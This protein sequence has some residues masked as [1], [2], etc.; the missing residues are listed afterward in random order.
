[1]GG[2]AGGNTAG[3]AGGNASAPNSDRDAGVQGGLD[4]AAAPADGDA[5]DASMSDG[6][7]A[8]AVL[9]PDASVSSC[10]GFGCGTTLS[11]LTAA[12][13]DG[14]VCVTAEALPLACDGELSRAAEQCT[15][16][17]ALSL[18]LG[19]RPVTTC[20]RRLP[21]LA[22]V[23]GDCLQCYADETLCTL[24]RCF[25]ACIDG[26]DPTCQQCRSSQCAQPFSQCSGLPSSH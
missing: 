11:S 19:G 5:L 14:G 20:M 8:P 15:Q 12:S 25:V 18:G 22:Q 17:N 7:C 3:S 4:A 9:A 21:K 10:A 24:S 26:S 16:E 1:L 23:S 13:R 6:G 2:I